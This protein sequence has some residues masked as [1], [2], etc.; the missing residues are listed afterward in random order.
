M[1]LNIIFIFFGTLLL[2]IAS[3]AAAGLPVAIY[4]SLYQFVLA[5]I[6]SEITSVLRELREPL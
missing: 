1:K 3:T 5:I 6:C 4:Y 2:A